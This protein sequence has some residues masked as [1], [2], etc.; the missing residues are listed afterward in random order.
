MSQEATVV[1]VILLIP[2]VVLDMQLMGILTSV[3]FCKKIY[4]FYYMT[5]YIWYL[6]ILI[7][8]LVVGYSAIILINKII[9]KNN[10]GYYLLAFDWIPGFCKS[11][12]DSNKPECYAP[13]NYWKN[14]LTLHGLWP[15]YNNGNI[16][17]NCP[18]NDFSGKYIEEI[19]MDVMRKYWPNVKLNTRSKKYNNFYK[20]EWQKHGSCTGLDEESYFKAAIN[21][22]KKYN[23]PRIISD[24]VGKI[25]STDDVR[26]S[27]SGK[28][29]ALRCYNDQY[30]TGVYTCW[31]K[32]NGIPQNQIDCNDKVVSEDNC[33]ND[34]IKI[35]SL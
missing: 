26:N 22:I 17:L 4:S 8:L 33:N 31:S 34:Y 16:K 15:D 10:L 2:L 30:L 6:I 18:N 5:D 20:H 28:K 29:V 9:Y 11:I 21:T 1:I 13:D 24:N 12:P 23:T 7:F 27:F 14:N 3:M 32:K 25:I 19:G 35:T